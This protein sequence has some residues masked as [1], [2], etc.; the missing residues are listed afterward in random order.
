MAVVYLTWIS[1]VR[2][3]NSF[4]YP[5]LGAIPFT[6]SGGCL[7]QENNC[8]PT[9]RAQGGAPS[10]AHLGQGIS[11]EID[12]SLRLP[13]PVGPPSELQGR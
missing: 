7:P 13:S 1:Q 12:Q 5:L 9:P 8:I 3:V 6:S 4:F 2:F 11:Q 10:K